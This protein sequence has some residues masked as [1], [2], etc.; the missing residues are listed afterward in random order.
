MTLT[1]DLEITKHRQASLSAELRHESTIRAG[2]KFRLVTGAV[3]APLPPSPPSHFSVM[4]EARRHA[5][6]DASM[7]RSRDH[8]ARRH[9]L[10]QD[11][12]SLDGENAGLEAQ[13]NH[14]H[15][16]LPT[17]CDPHS[18]ASRFRRQVQSGGT[19]KIAAYTPGASSFASTMDMARA[20]A[21]IPTPAGPR[22][23]YPYQSRPGPSSTYL[24]PGHPTIDAYSDAQQNARVMNAHV[25]EDHVAHAAAER[26]AAVARLHSAARDNLEGN[27]AIDSFVMTMEGHKRNVIHQARSPPASFS[28]LAPPDF[29]VPHESMRAEHNLRA[30]TGYHSNIF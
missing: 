10:L 15:V 16:A 3:P 11:L 6:D 30:Y 18:I 2:D 28:T 4:V 13:I 8:L 21:S 12:Q 23:M 27:A 5:N 9:R 17:M 24:P 19:G 1:R 14:M 22:V 7:A 29:I 25:M 26:D 20:T